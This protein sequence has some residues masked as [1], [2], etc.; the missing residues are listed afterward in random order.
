MIRSNGLVWLPTVEASEVHLDSVFL[1][2]QIDCDIIHKWCAHVSEETIRK[3]SALGIKGISEK[4]SRG[5]RLS[6]KSCVVSKSTIVD[7]NRV[8]TRDHDHESWF[9]TLTIDI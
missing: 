3:M 2:R 4:Y 7:I 1:S 5:M 9:H 8:S 6:C